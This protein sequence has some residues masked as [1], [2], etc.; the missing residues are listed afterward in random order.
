MTA[1]PLAMRRRLATSAAQ[2]AVLGGLVL[3]VLA[4]VLRAPYFGNPDYHV[5]EEFYFLVA[6]QMWK[7]ALPFTDIWDRKPL[8]LFL[9]YALLRPLSGNS[10]IAVQIAA[11]IFAWSTAMGVWLIARRQILPFNALIPAALYLISLCAFGGQNA[12]SPVFYNLPMTLAAWLCL[13]VAA[14]ED[15]RQLD[16][17]ALAIMTLVGIAIQIKYTALFEGIFF[18]LFLLWRARH[19]SPTWKVLT[20]RAL[21]YAGFAIAPTVTI[22]SIYMVI[23]EGWNFFFANF[24]SIFL[25][26]RLDE[27]YLTYLQNNIVVRGLPL[28]LLSS[29]AAANVLLLERP[30]RRDGLFLLGWSVAAVIGVCAI[31]NFYDHYALPMIAPLLA[32]STPLFARFFPGLFFLTFLTLWNNPF[33]LSAKMQVNE[34]S[35]TTISYLTRTALPYLDRGPLYI[36]DGPSILYVTTDSTP[37]TRFAYP[38]HLSNDVERLALDTDTRSEL[39]RI[40]VQK[41]AIIVT[42]TQKIVPVY[43]TDTASLMSE[44]LRRDYRLLARKPEGA[45]RRDY[46]L[47]VR[48]D[49]CPSC[50]AAP[51]LPPLQKR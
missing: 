47:N 50:P 46:I 38:D 2:P 27:T 19:L 39:E 44:A 24:I 28:F 21:F 12:Q 32:L 43:N 17:L 51:P 42:S 36:W 7:G 16:R 40:L 9:I 25:R 4:F 49:L 35:R 30:R 45:G 48:A 5:D 15:L 8:G 14:A 13:Q 23:G 37:P 3:L 31:G 1:L 41:P 6:D 18:G 26:A 29:A 10:L 11:L 34:A 20:T 22:L 33:H